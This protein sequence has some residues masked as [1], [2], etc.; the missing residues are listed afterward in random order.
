MMNT[1]EI[2]ESNTEPKGLAQL[3][4]CLD[5]KSRAILW[6]LW[7]H[8]HAELAE[9]RKVANSRDDY[10]VLYRLKEVINRQ[11][12]ELQGKPIAGF[13]QS[14]IDPLSGDKVLFSWW[15]LDTEDLAAANAGKRLVDIFDEQD[16]V[17][18][19]VQVPAAIHISAPEIQIKNG[20][21]K[22]K[23]AKVGC[24]RSIES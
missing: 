14:R 13:E 7:W 10:E 23:F 6:Y 2:S 12:Q 15:Y 20:I 8:R 5:D 17:T 22:M 1:L 19:F 11:S 4:E 3:L 18:I 9:L 16:N 21:L 24:E